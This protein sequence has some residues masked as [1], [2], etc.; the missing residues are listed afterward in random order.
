MRA[1]SEGVAVLQY[2]SSDQQTVEFLIPPNTGRPRG[3][4]VLIHG[5]YWRARFDATLMHPLAKDLT[6]RGWAVANI[7]YRRVGNGGGWPA[8]LDD[9]QAA[10]QA[11][12]SATPRD[13]AGLPVVGIGHSVGG[14]LALLAAEDL[15]AVV[16]LA[17]VTD[18]ARA[19][20]EG[21]GEG[22]ARQ[23]MGSASTDAARAFARASPIRR[24][25][26]GCPLLVVH[27]DIDDRV[28]VEHSQ[29]FTAAAKAAGDNVEFRVVPGLGHLEAID[30][31]AAHWAGV[32]EW[33]DGLM[34]LAG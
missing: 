21:L 23:F 5:G 14:Q 29:D 11:V 6:A 12:R 18:V 9:V 25:P 7:E 31:K 22:A 24:V 26:V 15:D 13:R 28:P 27:G 32:A 30:P 2:G 4:A 34:P 33:M 8:T 1:Q 3:T 19:D 10:L 20:R 16:A 17:P